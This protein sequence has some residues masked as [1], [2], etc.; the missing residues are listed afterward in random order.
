MNHLMIAFIFF[1]L[2]VIIHIGYCRKASLA[3]LQA[4]A[5]I[6]TALANGAIMIICFLFLTPS[7][8]GLPYTAVFL[9]VLAIPVYLVFYVSTLLMSPSKNILRVVQDDRGA[10]YEMILQ[11]LEQE[12]FIFLR[13][14]ELQDSGCV[15]RSGEKFVLT[16]SGRNIVR[17]LKIYQKVLGQ[18]PGG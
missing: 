5:F 15:R 9:Y 4:K 3:G 10:T 6:L 14:G 18:G 11:A 13:L 17:I 1:V 8:R 7:D 16:P 12:N 2:S